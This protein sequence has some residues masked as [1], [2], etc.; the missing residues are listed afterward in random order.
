ML[1]QGNLLWHFPAGKLWDAI[2]LIISMLYCNIPI[3]RWIYPCTFGLDR[4]RPSSLSMCLCTLLVSWPPF[5]PFPPL[6]LHPTLL[7]NLARS[8]AHWLN[9]IMIA[10]WSLEA[11][12]DSTLLNFISD[13]NHW[14]ITLS[15]M[16][17]YSFQTMEDIEIGF[18]PTFSLRLRLT[19]GFSSI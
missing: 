1:S 14:A 13:W 9:V 11:W 15:N 19:S 2:P 17:H 18:F 6:P 3:S 8:L 10:D 12:K 4:G 7:L 5:F 16:P